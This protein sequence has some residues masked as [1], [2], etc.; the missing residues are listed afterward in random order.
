[1]FPSASFAMLTKLSASGAVLWQVSQF[2]QLYQSHFYDVAVS[3]TGDVYV[4]GDYLDQDKV[5]QVVKYSS[6]RAQLWQQTRQSPGA[7][8]DVG[9]KLA[10][11]PAGNLIVGGNWHSGQWLVAKYDSSGALAWTWKSGPGLNG[12]LLDI[13]VD[14]Q[15]TTFVTGGLDSLANPGTRVASL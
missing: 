9:V 2:P 4:T 12:L 11:D 7:G 10:L 15:G 1:S 3:P 8:A 6:S 14:A 5:L 13:A